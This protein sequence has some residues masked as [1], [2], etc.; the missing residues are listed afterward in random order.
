MIFELFT[1]PLLFFIWTGALLIAVDIHEFA[2]AWMADRLGDPTPRINGRLTLN[3]LAHLDPI[4]TL[5]L[6]WTRFGWGKPVPIDDY[7][8]ENPRRDSALIALAGPAS[9]LILATFLS[10]AAKLLG[11]PLISLFITPLI[12]LNI[13]LAI[14]NLLPIPPLDG[15][16]ILLGILSSDLAYQ[17]V[18]FI[19]EYSLILLILVLVPFSGRSLAS[20]IILPIIN[21]LLDF[22]L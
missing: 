9:N 13:S 11:L 1:N 3:P 21:F 6:L 16:K 17:Y 20:Q 14:F 7:N 10:L 2:H 5:M 4:G 8:L 22:L 18:S 15:S 12:I 19:E